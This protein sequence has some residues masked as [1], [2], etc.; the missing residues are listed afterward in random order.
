MKNEE[1][2]FILE[3]TDGKSKNVD[4]IVAFKR[5]TLAQALL[6]HYPKMNVQQRLF[7][8]KVTDHE[9]LASVNPFTFVCERIKPD[10]I[11]QWKRN[12]QKLYNLEQT[13]Q[14]ESYTFFIECCDR[15]QREHITNLHYNAFRQRDLCVGAREGETIRDALKRDGRFKNID[16]FKLH[17]GPRGQSPSLSQKASTYHN[18]IFRVTMPKLAQSDVSFK[19]YSAGSMAGE[20]SSLRKTKENASSTTIGVLKNEYCPGD[21]G[22]SRDD[23]RQEEEE[24]ESSTKDTS[25]QRRG[26]FLF[27]KPVERLTNKEMFE[28]MEQHMLCHAQS[29]LVPDDQQ[30]QYEKVIS[31]LARAQFATQHSVA[32]PAR[33]TKALA[34]FVDSIGKIGCGNITATCFLLSPN[35]VITND[36]VI[37]MFINARL[38]SDPRPYR[39]IF[40][41]FDFEQAG[42]TSYHTYIKVRPLMTAGNLFSSHLDY[43]ILQLEESLK[44]KTPL[45]QYVRCSVPERGLV[46]IIGHP[47]SREKLEETSM[48]LPEKQRT[49]EIEGRIQDELKQ[50][51]LEDSA[52]K[53][54]H[55]HGVAWN[56]NRVMTY[57]VGTMFEGSS[58]SPVFNMSG[59]I[60]AL[61]S[62]GYRLNQK[63]KNTRLIELGVTFH[64][65]I[66]DLREKDNDDVVQELF[67]Y[68]EN[69]DMDFGN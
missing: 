14:V 23:E 36:H 22:S 27:S 25:T 69:E 55:M 5:E 17:H 37:R 19:L 26:L 11:V 38:S 4:E 2:K 30:H 61:H 31:D 68:C 52:V 44:D 66:K 18:V 21:G 57:D 47:G 64:T 53:C 32:R 43:A 60:V 3:W 63:K 12:E 46:T 56:N 35:V 45:G 50:W 59:E 34:L 24:K 48:I 29:V 20:K 16:R 49:K 39:D 15:E 6:R 13:T 7:W 28:E 8:A 41:V 51:Q 62:A 33:L 54:I 10:S 67:P 58:G 1:I 40:V 9:G 42:Q 65:I